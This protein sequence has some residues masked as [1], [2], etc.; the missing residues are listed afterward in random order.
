MST[1]TG[2][3]T[4]DA[5]VQLLIDLV[6]TP[7][8]SGS[9]RAAAEQFVAHAAERGF[10]TDIDEAGNACAHRGPI[11]ADLHI[12][13]LGH[14]DTVPGEIPVRIADGVLHGRGSVDAKGPLCAMLC[15]AH[16]A[17]LSERVRLSIIGAVGE[18][19]AGSPGARFLAPRLR[20]DACIIGEPSG[21]SGVTLGY[22]GRLLATATANC[23]NHHSAGEDPSAGDR[24][25]AWW[26]AVSGH[27]ST[28]NIERHSAFETLQA[29]IQSM[30]SGCDGLA[31]SASL[32]AGFRLPPEMHPNDLARAIESLAGDTVRVECIGL[33]LAHATHRNDPVV[34][35]LS[36]AIRASGG[37]PRPTLK[38][39]TADFNVVGPIWNC[40][41]A[42][43][44]PGD[45]SLDH[46]PLERIALDEY[47]RSIDVL[48]TAT[49]SLAAELSSARRTPAALSVE[50][51]P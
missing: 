7:S 14:I 18:E 29:T 35:A 48:A 33:E 42:A 41:I 49:T 1:Q 22:K 2:N 51:R 26:T 37:R 32:E 45:S 19:S 15:A 25:V 36:S 23:P 50:R 28:F 11:D 27:I 17:E 4:R 10:A 6:S 8:V 39:G 38:T 47:A 21:W 31:Q 5:D 34:R 9:E 13:M 40:P 44:G 46:T 24:L 43:Y 12:V 30:Q 20:P 3:S 16:K